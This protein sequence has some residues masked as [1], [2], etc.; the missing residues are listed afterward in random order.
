MKGAPMSVVEAHNQQAPSDLVAVAQAIMQRLEQAWNAGDGDAFAEPFAAD[1]DFVAIRGDL[2][3]GRN[4][5]AKGHQQIFD[6]I[7]AG[8]RVRYKVLQARELGPEA[9]LALARGSLDAPSGPL[10]GEH[11]STAT[12]VLLKRGDA[13]EITAFHNTLIVE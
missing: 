2:H 7:Y 13:Y 3:T 1:A 12:I 10:A 11:A 9:I 6:T 4:A 5:I 8:S